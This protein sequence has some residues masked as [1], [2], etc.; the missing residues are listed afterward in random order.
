MI[1]SE[2]YDFCDWTLFIMLKRSFI[3]IAED[4]D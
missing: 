2:E 4:D 3:N 1:S